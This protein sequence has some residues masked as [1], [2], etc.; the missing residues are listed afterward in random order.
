MIFTRAKILYGEG[1]Y[2]S[3]LQSIRQ[4]KGARLQNVANGTSSEELA[5]LEALTLSKLGMAPAAKTA[6]KKIAANPDSYYGQLAAQQLGISPTPSH[7]GSSG[8]SV[9]ESGVDRSREEAIDRLSRKRRPFL[10][11]DAGTRDVVGELMFLQLWDEASFWIDHT[12]RPDARLA[13]DLGYASGRYDRAIT[14]A[15][16]ISGSG[17]ATQ[18][19]LYP[20][21]FRETICRA[22]VQNGVDPLWLHAIIWQESKY[23]P[24]AVSGASARGLMQFIPDTAEALAAKAGVPDLTLDKLYDPDTSI[25]L[26][27]YYWSSLLS[28][29]ESPELALAA[30]NAGPD[31]VRRWRDKWPGSPEFF[32]LD[33]GFTET[34]RYVQA[35]FGARAVYGRGN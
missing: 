2:S 16:R 8:A 1:K 26:G 24:S 11:E 21:G 3:A 10:N 6:W 20:A 17:P 14:H 9:C 27:A 19:L 28:E 22:A 32:V 33:I 15:R 23:N 31:N 29:F 34:K 18:A 25:R 5:Y 35:V 30:Y 12:R 13:A 4:L 7:D